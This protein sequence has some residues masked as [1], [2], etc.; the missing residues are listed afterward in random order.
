MK[1]IRQQRDSSCVIVALLN[2]KRYYRLSTC[3]P[4]S[5]EYEKLIDMAVCRAGAAIHIDKVAEYLGLRRTRILRKDAYKHFPFTFA[6][7]PP[8]M[9]LHAVLAVGGMK[10][11]WTVVNYRAYRG[12]TVESVRVSDLDLLTL[13]R[14][15]EDQA[16]RQFWH[17]SIIR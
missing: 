17:I 12:S 4:G 2:A 11:I 13:P 7:F 14:G 16:F 10:D 9:T 1:Y 15:S 6:C 3:L 5:F 8:K